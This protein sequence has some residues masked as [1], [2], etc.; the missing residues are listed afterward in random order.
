MIFQD[1]MTSLNPVMTVEQIAEVRLHS[2]C[3]TAE[4]AVVPRMSDGN[5]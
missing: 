5:Q 4:A 2:H 3:Q 1:P